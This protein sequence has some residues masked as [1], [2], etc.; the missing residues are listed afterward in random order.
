V[1]CYDDLLF[2]TFGIELD[3]L[4][5][6]KCGHLNITGDIL[7]CCYF[8]YQQMENILLPRLMETLTLT[9]TNGTGGRNYTLAEEPEEEAEELLLY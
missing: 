2:S 6:T 7:D 8:C 5:G 9:S 3:H 4:T 1:L